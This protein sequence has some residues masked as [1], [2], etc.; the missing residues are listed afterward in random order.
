MASYRRSSFPHACYRPF[1]PPIATLFPTRAALRNQRDLLALSSL[2]L[3]VRGGFARG[4]AANPLT[5]VR[6]CADGWESG[7][8]TSSKLGPGQAE[9]AIRGC[10]SITGLAAASATCPQHI[11]AFWLDTTGPA[12]HNPRH[13]FVFLTGW[14]TR[15]V[16]AS[17]RKVADRS[18]GEKSHAVFAWLYR[19][20][21]Q[22]AL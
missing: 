20:M 21:Y 13:P 1:R 9:C 18:T 7:Q 12:S 14:G 17:R 4:R 6:P 15:G 16:C 22:S 10:V 2:N 5:T 11:V 8:A 3:T 19:S